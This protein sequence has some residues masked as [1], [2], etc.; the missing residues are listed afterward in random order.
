[1]SRFELQL[2]GGSLAVWGGESF[3]VTQWV[4]FGAGLRVAWNGRE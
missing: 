2:G 1:V 3:G 4:D